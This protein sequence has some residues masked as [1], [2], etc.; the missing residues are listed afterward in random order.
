MRTSTRGS[1]PMAW[2]FAE[3]LRSSPVTISEPQW[4]IVSRHVEIG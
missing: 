1:A 3:S 4:V 2:S